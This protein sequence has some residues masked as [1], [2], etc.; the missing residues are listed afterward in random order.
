MRLLTTTI[1]SYPKPDFLE[2]KDRVHPH[3]GYNPTYDEHAYYRNRKVGSDVDR[4][5]IRAVLR[6]LSAGIDVPTDGEQGREHYIAYHQRHLGGITFAGMQVKEGV[7]GVPEWDE[8][9]ATINGEITS[10]HRFLRYDWALAQ[11]I[12]KTYGKEVK[13]T[14]PGPMTIAD[15]SIDEFYGDKRKLNSALARA[16]N[17]EIL[18][19]VNAG[20]KWIQVDEPLF[21]RFPDDALEYGIENLERCFYGVPENVKRVVH[22]C[23]GYPRHVDQPGEDILKADPK[24]YFELANALDEASVDAVS[25]EDAHKHNDLSLLERF[26]NT[27][28]IVGSVAI[29]KSRVE[30]VQEIRVR[31]EEVLE[32][33]DPHRLIVGPD[34]GLGMLDEQTA[35]AKLKNM[36][37]T[38]NLFET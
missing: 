14:L 27:S 23:C 33:I 38:V 31:L 4:A 34:C 16:I 13:T 19:L 18:D 25:L 37:M 28:V 32:H 15:H 5:T 35:Y 11:E 22:L 24:S 30:H 26:R 29:A 12:A 9:V 20:C 2:I 36:V 21:A 10:Q 6:Q 8:L 17:V 3:S 7:R 1:G